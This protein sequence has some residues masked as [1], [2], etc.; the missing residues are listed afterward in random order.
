MFACFTA[1]SLIGTVPAAEC[2]SGSRYY[3]V[4]FGGQSVPFKPRT[5]HT[6]A[7]FV[8]TTPT[9]DGR[10]EVEQV[11]ISW[12]PASGPVQPLRIRPV[13]GKNYTLDETFAKMTANNAQVSVWGPFETDAQRYELA[14]RQANTLGS[15]AVTFRSVD[16]FRGNRAVQNCV[17]AVTYADPK[18]QSLRQPVIRVGEPGTSRLAAM[19][20]DGGAVAGPQAHPEVLALIGADRYPMIPR[21]AGE[22]LRRQWR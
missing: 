18:L 20:V 2:A 21:A 8:K 16:S 14:V 19:Y 17:H 13:E 11:T 22:R 1:L 3:F 7:T 9:A 4:L 10:L 5:A 6:W 12:L 15:G